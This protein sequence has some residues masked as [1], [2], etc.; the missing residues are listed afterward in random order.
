MCLLL[1][2]FWEAVKQQGANE[3]FDLGYSKAPK[4]EQM[5]VATGETR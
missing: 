3:E 2:L 1:S 4:G 5:W